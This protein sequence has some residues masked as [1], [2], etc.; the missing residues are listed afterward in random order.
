VGLFFALRHKR[1]V[2]TLRS[3]LLFFLIS[4]GIG[5]GLAIASLD[6]SQLP[7]VMQLGGSGGSETT[8]AKTGSE[9]S[10]QILQGSSI[11][12]NPSYEPSTA[13]VSKD[14]LITW[15]NEDAAPHTATS[16]AG[17]DD[18]GAG[19]LFDSGS[20]GKGQ[21]FSV[22][23]GNLGAGKFDYYCVVHPFMKGSITV[24]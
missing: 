3:W 11:Q 4:L 14:D 17:T 18:P 24:Q 16:G 15:I 12:G 8:T 6:W 2:G 9:I 20:L 23:A 21:K 1:N 22:P 7:T 19:K 5:T 13:V 10:I